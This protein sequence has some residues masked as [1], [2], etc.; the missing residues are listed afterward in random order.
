[1]KAT[2]DGIST[3]R[4]V[5]QSLAVGTT[6]TTVYNID[7]IHYLSTTTDHQPEIPD[8]VNNNIYSRYLAT[9]KEYKVPG[10]KKE[11]RRKEWKEKKRK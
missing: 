1:M 9:T 4:H 2:N 7:Y 10:I 6:A 11:K 3:R 8:Y 5:R